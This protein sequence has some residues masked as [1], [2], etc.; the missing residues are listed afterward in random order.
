[1]LRAEKGF[2]IVGQETDGSVNPYDLGM[3]WI[4]SKTKPDFIGKRALS[5]ES[6]GY[7]NRKQLIGLYAMILKRLSQRER[8][9]LL[10]LISLCQWTCLGRSRLPIFHQIAGGQ[11]P[12]QCLRAVTD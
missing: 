2:I 4:I 8:M 9:Q 3:D 12:W 11:L 1:M 5:R 6:M 10:I 7:D